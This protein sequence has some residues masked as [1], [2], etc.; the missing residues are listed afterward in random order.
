M[1]SKAN[2]VGCVAATVRGLRALCDALG[3]VIDRYADTAPAFAEEAK[4][5][6]TLE[7]VRLYKAEQQ[8]A[9]LIGVSV[10]EVRAC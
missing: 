9:E 2:R 10:E 1:T 3:M 8:Y 6:W 5:R 4:Q 7:R